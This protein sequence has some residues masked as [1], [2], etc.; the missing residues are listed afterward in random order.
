M[1]TEACIPRPA[2]IL[3][4]IQLTTQPALFVA[5]QIVLVHQ[6][7]GQDLPSPRRCPGG[8][9]GELGIWLGSDASGWRDAGRRR[10]EQLLWARGNHRLRPRHVLTSHGRF[11][12]TGLVHRR[13]AAVQHCER[14]RCRLRMRE[15]PQG[16]PTEPAQEHCSNGCTFRTTRHSSQRVANKALRRTKAIAPH[17]NDHVRRPIA[18]RGRK[19]IDSCALGSRA[20]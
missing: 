7:I 9:L 1:R 6:A 18:L 15:R 4:V 16:S 13:I 12:G 8:R 10:V 5:G 17:T 14:H 19:S 3:V 20:M 11:C 2:D